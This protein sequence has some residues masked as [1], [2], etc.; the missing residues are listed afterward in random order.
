MPMTYTVFRNP[1]AAQACTTSSHCYGVAFG[2]LSGII[3]DAVTIEPSCLSIPSG[4][5]VTDEVWLV[6]ANAAHWVEV[7]YLQ[8]GGNLNVGGITAAGRYG[9]WGDARPGSRL[10]DHV[11]QN[12]PPLSPGVGAQ[13]QTNGHDSWGAY[14]NGIGGFSTSNT[15]TPAFGEWGSETTSASAH[16]ISFGDNAV[17]QTAS[18]WHVGV[19]NQPSSGI[20]ANSPQRFSWAVNYYNYVAG[21]PC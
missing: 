21:V 11:L 8:H 13:I 7:G 16:S 15:M 12:N 20:S 10:F 5:F 4:N 14:F 6:D 18:G 1:N 19:P 3:G 2:D 9:F 17:Y